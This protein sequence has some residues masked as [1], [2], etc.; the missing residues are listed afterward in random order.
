MTLTVCVCYTERL[1]VEVNFKLCVEVRG[2]RLS[3]TCV[4]LGFSCSGPGETKRWS[5]EKE[6]QKVSTDLDSNVT[7]LRQARLR[8]QCPLNGAARNAVSEIRNPEHYLSFPMAS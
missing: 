1:L 7:K 5:L 2:Q 4:Y 8:I 6:S 3:W